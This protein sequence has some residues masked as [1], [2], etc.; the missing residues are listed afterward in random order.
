[1]A[2][3][4]EQVTTLTETVLSG[5][6]DL[7]A[8]LAAMETWLNEHVLDLNPADRQT[9]SASLDVESTNDNRSL[10]ESVLKLH[11]T[12]LLYRY[13]RE[14]NPALLEAGDPGYGQARAAFVRALTESED[15]IN[16]ARID[17]A[18]ANAHHLLGN[19]PANRQWLDRALER[20]PALAAM[21][22]VGLAQAIPA[23]PLPGLGRLKRFGL[24]LMGFNFERLAQYNRDSLVIVARMQA[25]QVVLLA[26]L[27]GT[28][29]EA[30]RERQRANRAYRAA[31]HVIARYGG[32]YGDD[33]GQMFEIADSIR[34]TEPD[35][36]R[37]LIHQARLL[38]ETA[39][40]TDGM[41]HADALLS[42]F[43]D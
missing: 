39:G 31:A 24:K 4:N 25:N 15:G 6:H 5:S 42:H 32:M 8:A 1:M 43:N 21:D 37:I 36:A 33:T 7:E 2:L 19:R 22:L 34:A 38:C 13:D 26:H 11:L 18:V 28:S 41:T 29:F 16:E 17:I 30:I 12:R 35:S 23:I 3:L 20:L 40:D 14:H 27:V 9:F 10:I